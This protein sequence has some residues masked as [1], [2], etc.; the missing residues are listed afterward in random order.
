[1][2]YTSIAAADLDTRLIERIRAAIA[3]EAQNNATLK[4]SV[5]GKAVNR[6]GPDQIILA[7]TWAVAIDY[8]T[9][10]AYALGSNNTNPGGDPG[11]ISD[12]NIQAAIVAHWPTI[13]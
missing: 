8:E 2:S 10:Y 7:L 13:V 3:Q 11:V 6:F 1:M 9:E 12:A 5:A 4:D